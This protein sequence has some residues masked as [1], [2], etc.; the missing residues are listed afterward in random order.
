M[1]RR[2]FEKDRQRRN[3]AQRGSED[4]K[5]GLPIP[6]AGPRK[7]PSKADQRTFL[8]DLLSHDTQIT[9][10][11]QCNECGDRF[12]AKEALQPKQPIPCR[13]CGRPIW[14]KTS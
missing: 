7:Q 5:G 14:T 13:K 9:R 12:S 8:N 4:V 10:Q 6:G 3:V 11:F 1:G 2:D